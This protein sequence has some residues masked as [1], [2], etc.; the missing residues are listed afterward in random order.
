M[1]ATIQFHAQAWMNSCDQAFTAIKSGQTYRMSLLS[2]QRF[3]VC[4]PALNMTDNRSLTLN[5]AN[6]N[7]RY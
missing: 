4:P 6:K 3:H 5:V 7:Q 1:S 2:A